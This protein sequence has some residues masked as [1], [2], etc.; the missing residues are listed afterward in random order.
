[1]TTGAG[2][3]TRDDSPSAG[4]GPGGPPPP[5]FA[6]GDGPP[7]GLW[8]GRLLLIAAALLSL[9]SVFFVLRMLDYLR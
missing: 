3:E 8:T 4:D 7:W 5:R 9:A 1:M 6:E 2:G